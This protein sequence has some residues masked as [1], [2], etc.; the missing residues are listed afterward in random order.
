M[1]IPRT[2]TIGDHQVNRIGLGTNRL[3]DTLENR[4]FLTRAVEAGVNFI[5]TAHL[6]TGGASEQAIGAALAPFPDDLV[7]ASKAGYHPGS[8][9][10]ERLRAEV[11]ESFERLR[12]E[13]ITSTTCIGSTPGC[14]SRSR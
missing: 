1:S 8:G 4:D 11:E 9:R 7:V 5:D 12:S 14:P 3:M 6:Y 13:T 2:T 10:P